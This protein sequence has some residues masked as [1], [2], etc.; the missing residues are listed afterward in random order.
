MLT[1]R[2]DFT[3]HTKQILQNR[4]ASRCSYPSCRAVTAG[5]Q[6][7]PSKALNIG[8]AAHITAATPNGPRYDQSLTA[9]QRSSIS[10]GIWLCQNCA[11]LVDND[12]PRFTVQVLPTWKA[13]AEEAA[14]HEIGRPATAS[15]QATISRPIVVLEYEVNFEETPEKP[16]ALHNVSATPAFEVQISSIT[17]A[18]DSA[19]FDLV[20]RV[21]AH[22]SRNVMPDLP[23]EGL[24]FR[25]RLRPLLD[26][27]WH[28]QRW[29]ASQGL[30][31]E[32]IEELFD[33]PIVL[34]ITVTYRGAI[35]ET[36][37]EQFELVYIYF[38]ATAFVR[39][40]R[41]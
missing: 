31:R 25:W 40:P 23:H 22:E 15:A 3:P 26:K 16:F 18:G 38:A 4:V 11:K 8:V 27:A 5:P 13:E 10:N 19:E 36:Y 41:A 24:V 7:D 12:P 35:R 32:K 37:V 28:E 9:E 20:P 39:F 17:Y 33:Q 2:D 29:L 30:P 21:E 34:P 1:P 6:V 14:F